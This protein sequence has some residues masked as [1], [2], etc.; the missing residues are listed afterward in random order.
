MVRL[1]RMYSDQGT[2][3]YQ[4]KLQMHNWRYHKKGRKQG[5]HDNYTGIGSSVGSEDGP[6][7]ARGNVP[8]MLQEKEV[9]GQKKKRSTNNNQS[10]CGSNDSSSQSDVHIKKRRQH[11]KK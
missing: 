7:V 11:K 6:P 9:K 3:R 1:Q 5:V 4:K 2:I 8:P 10:S